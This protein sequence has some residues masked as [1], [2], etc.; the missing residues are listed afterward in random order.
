MASWI[1]NPLCLIPAPI[2]KEAVFAPANKYSDSMTKG[3]HDDEKLLNYTSVFWWDIFKTFFFLSQQRNSPSSASLLSPYS[4]SF[5]ALLYVTPHP[6][7]NNSRTLYTLY[8]FTS[9]HLSFIEN[10][11]GVSATTCC[12]QSEGVYACGL[13]VCVTVSGF[14]GEREEE[15]DKLS[16]CLDFIYWV[17]HTHRYNLNIFSQSWYKYELL[18]YFLNSRQIY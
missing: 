11:A 3:E 15:V 16:M 8:T 7:P 10:G 14:R 9:F 6:L 17:S 5:W 2:R 4:D 12:V 1:H 18:F 13:F